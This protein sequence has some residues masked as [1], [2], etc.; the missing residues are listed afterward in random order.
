VTELSAPLRELVLLLAE[1]A[2]DRV[3]EEQAE[4]PSTR[5]REPTAQASA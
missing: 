2:V 4:N 3:L 5:E 1:A